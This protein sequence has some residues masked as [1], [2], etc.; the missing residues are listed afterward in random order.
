MAFRTWVTFFAVLLVT[1]LVSNYVHPYTGLG[2]SSTGGR[3]RLSGVGGLS[4]GFY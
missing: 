4:A 2:H 1:L 3:S